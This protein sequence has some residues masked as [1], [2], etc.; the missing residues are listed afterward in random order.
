LLLDEYMAGWIDDKRFE[1]EARIWPNYITDYKPVVEYARKNSIP[2]VATNIPRRYSNMVF[3][4]GF[5]I[6]DSLNAEAKSYIAPLP[7]RYDPELG[8]YKSMLQMNM[9]MTH[10]TK[11]DDKFPKAQAIKDATMAYFILKTYE[12]GDL[13]YHINGAFHSDNFEG[14]VWYIKQDRPG[15]KIV[16]LTNVSQDDPDKLDEKNQGKATY[17]LVV[18]QTMT[19]TQQTQP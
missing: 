14:I 18:P 7:I 1:G 13:F 17:I 15:L 5:E 4:K 6:L 9:G 16:T 8:C 3:K 11:P 19:K 10:G 2:F 12:Q